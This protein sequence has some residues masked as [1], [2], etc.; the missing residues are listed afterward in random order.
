MTAAR[1]SLIAGI[2]RGVGIVVVVGAAVSCSSSSSGPSTKSATTARAGA[3]VAC[4]WPTR[5]DKATLNIAYPDTSSTYWATNYVLAPGERLELRGHFPNAR[6]MSFITYGAAGGAIDV[7]TDRQIVADRG[8]RNPFRVRAE[9]GGSYTVVLRNDATHAA[10]SLRV[11]PAATVREPGSSTSVASSTTN[12]AAPVS[13]GSGSPGAPGVVGGTVIYRVYLSN[14]PGD[15]TGG[16]GLAEIRDVHADGSS[17]IVA[18]CPHPGPNPSAIGL[19]SA[20]GPATDTPAPAQP[21]FIR[22]Q[23]SST[24]LYPDPDNVYLATIVHYQPGQIVVVRAKAPTF[25][26]TKRGARVTGA[27]QVRYWS[28]CSDA[29]R[30]PYPVSFCVADQDVALDRTGRY[31]I[32]VSTPADRPPNATAQNGVTWLDWGDTT[33]DNLL[34][35]RNMLA[36]PTFR[37]SAINVLVGS[38][39][40]SS[41]GPYA[42]KGA[43]CSTAAFARRGIAGCPGL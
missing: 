17:T 36:A 39:A 22:P 11:A 41:M 18:P 3:R 8:S 21:T 19:V 12:P 23:K 38:L 33:V 1:C 7:L 25:P 14:V 2:A 34:L 28:L 6:Y 42:P 4:A 15:L 10:N 16:G 13:L 30:K 31:T 5:A 35:M 20:N 27:E 40:S 9:T 26:N 37:E 32:V 24:N 29:Y 43:Y